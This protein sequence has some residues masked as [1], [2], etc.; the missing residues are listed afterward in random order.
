MVKYVCTS[1]LKSGYDPDESFQAWLD[2]HAQEQII[3]EYAH[4]AF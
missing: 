2:D 3:N 4:A 1:Q